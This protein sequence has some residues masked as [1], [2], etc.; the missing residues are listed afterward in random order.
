[1]QLDAPRTIYE[2]PSCRFVAEFIGES[3]FL[4]V[5]G[6]GGA[7]TL[8]GRPLRL[9]EGA[10]GL[11]GDG[12]LMLRPEKL[13]ILAEAEPAGEEAN[14]LEGRVSGFIYQGESFVLEVELASGAR[15][16]LRGMSTSGTIDTLPKSGQAARLALD[17]RDTFLVPLDGVPPDGRRTSHDAGHGVSLSGQPGRSPG[18][19]DAATS[20]PA[21]P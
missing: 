4:P 12:L 19:P 6:S 5:R 20:G 2:R 21:R 10:A 18:K 17:R 9:A 3:A 14:L 11:E 8:D 13:R 7:V 15:V 1:M 16:N